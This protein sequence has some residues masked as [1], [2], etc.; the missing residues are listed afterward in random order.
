MSELNASLGAGIDLIMSEPGTPIWMKL[1][2][3]MGTIAILN[4]TLR[5]GTLPLF[6]FFYVYAFFKWVIGLF[7][8]KVEN[9]SC[10]EY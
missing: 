9:E 5:T 8:K 4:T 1:L 2:A 10:V 3:L 6:F 7:K